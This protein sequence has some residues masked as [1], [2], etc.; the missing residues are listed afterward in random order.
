MAKINIVYT[1]FV[2]AFI[3]LGLLATSSDAFAPP[4]SSLTTRTLIPLLASKEPLHVTSDLSPA[5]IAN[6]ATAPSHSESKYGTWS[7][8]IQADETYTR[9]IVEGGGSVTVTNSNGEM[10]RQRISPGSLVEITGDGGESQLVWDIDD[11]AVILYS[12]EGFDEQQKAAIVLIGL[13][14]GACSLA[15]LNMGV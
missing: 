15:Y 5:Q 7:E 11:E 3:L 8:S 1:S 9:F 14:A 6:L 12:G 10:T 13:L 2:G 4:P